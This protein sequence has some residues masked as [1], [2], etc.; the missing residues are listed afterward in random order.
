MI[1]PRVVID[2]AA[3]EFARKR[4]RLGDGRP[5]KESSSHSCSK[6]CRR[7]VD[8]R[9]SWTW[10]VGSTLRGLRRLLGGDYGTQHE[11]ET[12]ATGREAHLLGALG[13][14]GPICVNGANDKPGI[15]CGRD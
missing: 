1:P 6:R 11:Q 3:R 13:K 2:S 10:N 14:H 15:R 9:T 12:S 4:T 7:C 8:G 5:C